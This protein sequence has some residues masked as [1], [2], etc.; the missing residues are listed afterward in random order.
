MDGIEIEIQFQNI[1]TRFAK[2]SQVAVLPMFL[3]ER[4]HVFF[5]HSA[6]P[7]NTRYLEFRGRRRNFGVETRARSSH[8]VNGNR[9]RW[10]FR[11]SFSTS[12]FTRS[13]KFLFVGPRFEPLLA[14]ASY[15]VPALDGRE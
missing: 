14:V 7:G 9:R 1:H 2:E 13:S 6:F 3:D 15:P 12:P 10:I 8:Q 11:L 4:A 5:F